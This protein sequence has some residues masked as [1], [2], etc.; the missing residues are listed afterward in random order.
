MARGKSDDFSLFASRNWDIFLRDIRDGSTKVML[1]Q[2]HQESCLVERHCSAFSLRLESAIGTP[3]IGG[4]DPGSLSTSH[5]YIGIPIHIR[6][7]S[8]II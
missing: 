2:R 1:V 3:N 6:E 8:G 7:E 5:R 4:G